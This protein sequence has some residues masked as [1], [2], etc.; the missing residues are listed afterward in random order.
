M[1]LTADLHAYHFFISL[2]KTVNIGDRVGENNT[3]VYVPYAYYKF[4][5]GKKV[6]QVSL[7]SAVTA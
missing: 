4:Y 7:K 3:E 2:L 5:F 6:K 1:C